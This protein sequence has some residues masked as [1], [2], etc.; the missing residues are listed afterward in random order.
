MKKYGIHLSKKNSKI[1]FKLSN[2]MSK[3]WRIENEEKTKGI[4]C[5]ELHRECW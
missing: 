2:L 3:E 4:A 1:F 5:C